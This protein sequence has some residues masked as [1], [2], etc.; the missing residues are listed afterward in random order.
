MR[1]QFQQT[2]RQIGWV[3]SGWYALSRGLALISARRVRLFRYYLVAQPVTTVPFSKGRGAAIDVREVM[4]GELD[5]SQFDRPA[6]VIAERYRRGGRCLAAWKDGVLL[7]Y[8]WFTL[9][10]YQEDEVRAVFSPG[11]GVAWDFDVQIFPKHQFTM[12]F[13]RL[14]DRANLLLHS[15]GVRWSCSRISAFNAASG[16]AHRRLGARRIATALFL[17]CGK[18]QL[19]LATQLPFVQ[20]SVG[21]AGAPKFRLA[22]AQDHQQPGETGRA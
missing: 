21:A 11:E 14:W 19:T 17:V 9:A 10:D 8:L 12:A 7:G 20:L 18:W 4:E 16:A 15:L 22:P 6:T 5:A 3:N 2:V 13:P 1:K